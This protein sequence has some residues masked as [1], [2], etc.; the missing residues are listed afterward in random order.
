MRGASVARA[1]AA[2]ALLAVAL[3][4]GGV[5][6]A[7]HFLEAP[8]QQP[9]PADL[10]A[11]LGGDNGGRASRVLDLYRNGFAPKVLLTGSEGHSKTRASSLGWRARYLVDEG[12]PEHA[13]LYD[14]LSASTWEEAVNTLR[15]MQEAKLDRVL[16]VSDAPHMRRL[17][18]VWSK[19]FAGSGKQFTLV[20]SDMEG[21]DAAG[22]WRSPGNAQFVFGECIKLAYYLFAH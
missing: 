1:L 16:V 10:I 12:I 19:A 7:G 15:L 6:G 13:L 2:V 9:V 21:W 4:I 18:W 20:A 22:W 11:A 5:F 8:A 3:C 14:S 17:A